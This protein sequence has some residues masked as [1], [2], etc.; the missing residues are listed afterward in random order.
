MLITDLFVNIFFTFPISLGKFYYLDSREG[1]DTQALRLV[2]DLMT[3]QALLSLL[4]QSSTLVVRGQSALSHFPWPWRLPE[5]LYYVVALALMG[6]QAG[7]MVLRE[8]VQGGRGTSATHPSTT[9]HTYD[10]LDW[11]VWLLMVLLPAVGVLLG[12]VING[13][14]DHHYRRY[15]QF[16]RLEFE[17]RL[18]MH[19]PR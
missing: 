19:S 7:I 6:V 16:L 18:G 4:S 14:D 2:Q 1:A 9:A 12:V 10:N 13:D 5:S 3:T 15:L 11:P 17:T 8:D